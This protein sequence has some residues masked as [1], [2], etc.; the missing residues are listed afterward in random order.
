MRDEGY[1]A[2]RRIVTA[3]LTIIAAVLLFGREAVQSALI[4]L[5]WVLGA[6]AGVAGVIALLALITWAGGSIFSEIEK[7]E[8]AAE[9]KRAQ[10]RVRKPPTGMAAALEKLGWSFETW[11]V[12]VLVGLALIVAT[13]SKAVG[14]ID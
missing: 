9:A 8:D 13:I 4:R 5:G 11:T 14:L 1:T 2:H 6:L 3:L 10:T 12:I 7:E